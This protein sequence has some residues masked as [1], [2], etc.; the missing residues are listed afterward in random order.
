M[1]LARPRRI[2][3]SEMSDTATPSGLTD[4][5]KAQLTMIVRKAVL[6]LCTALLA[7]HVDSATVSGLSAL[8]DPSA[9]ASEIVGLG[10]IAWSAWENR[11]TNSKIVIAAATGIATATPTTADTKFLL[12]QG[13]APVK[14][15]PAVTQAQSPS[16]TPAP[17]SGPAYDEYVAAA[18]KFASSASASAPNYSIPIQSLPTANRPPAQ[19]QP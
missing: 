8:I 1:F 5:A 12:Q 11:K 16:F 6:V 14:V 18:Q 10:V 15:A 17:T 9:I 2:H 19:G 7:H 4:L 3:P 13:I